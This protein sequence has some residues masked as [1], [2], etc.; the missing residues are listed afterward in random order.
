[1]RW[2]FQTKVPISAGKA[3]ELGL[4][5]AVFMLVGQHTVSGPLRNDQVAASIGAGI[6]IW[7]VFRYFS[8]YTPPKQ[9]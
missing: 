6:G 1:M 2:K 4:W 5:A 3:R 7:F 9:Q 8:E